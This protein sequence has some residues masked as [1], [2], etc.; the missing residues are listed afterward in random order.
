MHGV[1]PVMVLVAL[2]ILPKV[3]QQEE[4]GAF[5]KHLAIGFTVA[6]IYQQHTLA[7]GLMHCFTIEYLL[8][9]NVTRLAILV[10]GLQ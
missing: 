8:L 3:D 10:F 6:G 4:C 1:V 2:L 7:L 9:Q 5:M